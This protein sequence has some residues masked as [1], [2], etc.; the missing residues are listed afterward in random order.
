MYESL[1]VAILIA[2]LGGACNILYERHFS[3]TLIVT[4]QLLVKRLGMATL[5]G[6]AVFYGMAE[7]ASTSFDVIELINSFGYN[8][9][10][11]FIAFGIPF[12]ASGYF[13]DDILDVL[14]DNLKKKFT[15]TN[16]WQK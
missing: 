1:I 14:W 8:K 16:G 15:K 2:V 7:P 4:K 11:D 5:A 9:L 13:A 3:K 10:G 6:G 12:A